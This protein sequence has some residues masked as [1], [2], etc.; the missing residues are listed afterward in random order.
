[1][2]TVWVSGD[3]SLNSSRLTDRKVVLGLA[4]M[5]KDR[6]LISAVP[7]FY[8]SFGVLWGSFGGPLGFA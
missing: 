6:F 3:F 5:V 7:L 4:W 8:G 1:M 2:P